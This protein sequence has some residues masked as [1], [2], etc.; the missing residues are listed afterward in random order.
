MAVFN[1][2][3]QWDHT[4]GNNADT[5]TLPDNAAATAGIA[6]LQ[7][8]FQLINATPLEAGGIAPDREDV[9]A[10]F[11]LLGDSIFYAMTGGIAS[12]NAA[13]DYPVGALVKY[14]N[15]LYEAIQANGP[16]STVAAPTDSTY[17]SQIPTYADL[18][19]LMPTGVVLPFGGSTVP[20][21]WLLANGAAVSRSGKERLFS[22]YGTTFGAGD[23]ST[24]FNLPDL[25]DRYIIGVNTKALGTQIAEQLPN[26]NGTGISRTLTTDVAAMFE[27]MSGAL[28]SKITSANAYGATAVNVT[29]ISDL[30]FNANSS[31][32]IYTDSGKVYP[33][34]LALNFIIKT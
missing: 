9:N 27:G 13:Y 19:D 16:D 32:S 6:S 22:V 12:Y 3:A 18:S 31:N 24:T 23:G 28:S 20:N 33:L 11:K 1:E 7:K 2:P 26:I 17:W 15:V 25:R 4:L 21:G 30:T 10:L 5:S 29:K 8:L 14:N 34:S